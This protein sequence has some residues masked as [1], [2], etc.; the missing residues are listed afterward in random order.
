MQAALRPGDV[1]DVRDPAMAARWG[2]LLI[3]AVLLWPLL[4][5]TEF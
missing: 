2:S 5:W 4:V 3:G 1:R